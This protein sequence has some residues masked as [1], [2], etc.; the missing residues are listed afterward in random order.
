M[1]YLKVN[2]VATLASEISNSYLQ[3]SALYLEVFEFLEVSRAHAIFCFKFFQ[4]VKVLLVLAPV[5]DQV[6]KTFQL[7]NYITFKIPNVVF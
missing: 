6:F 5:L 1:T 3:I 7:P 2:F 4:S